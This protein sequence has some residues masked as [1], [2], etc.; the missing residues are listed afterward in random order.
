LGRRQWRIGCHLLHEGDIGHLQRETS[1]CGAYGVDGLVRLGASTMVVYVRA[2]S[3]F[4]F[5]LFS[6]SLLKKQKEKKQSREEEGFQFVVVVCV[7]S[8]RCPNLTERSLVKW[9]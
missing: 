4:P 3:S 6:I 8:C 5:G 9:F 1:S 7:G 2:S